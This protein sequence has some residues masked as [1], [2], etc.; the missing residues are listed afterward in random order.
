MT[1][2]GQKLTKVFDVPHAICRRADTLVLL[3]LFY[4]LRLGLRL[5]VLGRY[6]ETG[7]GGVDTG[8]FFRHDGDV[9]RLYLSV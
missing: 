1:D 2:T 7:D 4:G 9:P 5:L 6:R 8:E 3:L